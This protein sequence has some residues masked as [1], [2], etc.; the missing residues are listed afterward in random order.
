MFCM[1]EVISE[2]DNDLILIKNSYINIGKILMN[3]NLLLLIFQSTSYIAKIKP[4]NAHKQ[5]TIYYIV[6]DF[7]SGKSCPIPEPVN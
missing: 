2:Y 3:P 4:T 6:A 1:I 5:E 7:F